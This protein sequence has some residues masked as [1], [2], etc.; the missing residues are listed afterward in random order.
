MCRGVIVD[1]CIRKGSHD[2]QAK[3][4]PGAANSIDSVVNHRA[5]VSY[6]NC[7]RQTPSATYLCGIFCDPLRI[8]LGSGQVRQKSPES[9]RCSSL[10][11]TKA[12][13][14]DRKSPSNVSRQEGNHVIIMMCR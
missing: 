14:A 4:S 11:R 1:A 7:S 2:T 10:K 5:A 9:M 12:L 8:V 3:T 6:T 13:I